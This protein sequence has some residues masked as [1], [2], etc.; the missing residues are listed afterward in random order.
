[1]KTFILMWNPAFSSYTMDRFK[2]DLKKLRNSKY[3]YE[4]VGNWSIWEHEQAECGDRFFMVRVGEGNTGI[5]MSGIFISEP[6]ESE[7]WSG[8]GRQTFYMD[9]DIEAQI[10][11]D[12]TPIITTDELMQA[13]PGFDWT[14]GHSGRLLSDEMGIQLEKLWLDYLYKHQVAF[15]TCKPYLRASEIKHLHS[16]L[17]EYLQKEQG[18][19]CAICGYNYQKIF[20]KGCKN[21]IPYYAVVPKSSKTQP[22]TDSILD[23]IHCICSNCVGAGE[24]YIQKKLNK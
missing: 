4:G 9:L 18:C 22:A 19:T 15:K 2:A 7:D 8:K 3:W 14:G 10:D 11:S 13:L 21:E 5:V 6:Y 1:M 17:R 24:K 20:G 16:N 23:H 12:T